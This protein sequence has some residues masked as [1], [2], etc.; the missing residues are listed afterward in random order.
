ML[1]VLVIAVI[2]ASVAF[3]CRGKKSTGSGIASETLKYDSTYLFDGKS[4]NG[5]EITNF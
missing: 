1:R 2:I 4:L 5:W 3:A